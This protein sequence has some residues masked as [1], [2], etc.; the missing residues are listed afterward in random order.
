MDRK[1]PRLQQLHMRLIENGVE[2]S[3]QVPWGANWAV[4]K[5]IE[6]IVERIHLD[7][8]SFIDNK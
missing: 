2:Q 1:G 7:P 3:M 5:R 4:V 8:R 6:W